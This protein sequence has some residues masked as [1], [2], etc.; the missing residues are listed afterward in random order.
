MIVIGGIPCPGEGEKAEWGHAIVAVGFDDVRQIKNIKSNKETTGVL[1]IRNSRGKE[2][3]N[4]GYG[5]LP[6]D[7]ILNNVA[8]DFWSLPGM[9][10]V[11]SKQFGI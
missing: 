7:Y 8:S 11:D 6:Y 1:L 2:W 9:E 4:K 5:W 3:G 10:W